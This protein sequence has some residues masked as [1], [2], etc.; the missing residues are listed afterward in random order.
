MLFRSDLTIDFAQHEV[1]IG[2]RVVE[3]TPIEFRLLSY[4]ARNVG[5][6]VTPGLLLEHGWG[7]AYAS[8]YHL[9]IVNINRLRRKVEPDPSRPVYIVTRK[10]VG[11]LMPSQAVCSQPAAAHTAVRSTEDVPTSATSH[12]QVQVTRERVPSRRMPRHSHRPDPPART[13][14][15]K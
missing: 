9:L 10:G 7:E 12:H 13:Y 6:V 14:A 11:Y 5:H 4:L 8:E 1:T 15:G 3:L 2:E